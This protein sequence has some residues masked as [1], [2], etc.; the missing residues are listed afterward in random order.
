MLYK[1]S[2]KF[3]FSVMIILGLVANMQ[4]I[5]IAY[6]VQTLTNI[7][8]RK[9]WGNLFQFFLVISV[10]FILI[11]LS[12]LIFNRLKTDTVRDVNIYLRTNIFRGMLDQTKENNANGLG[13]LTND[14]KLLE[15]NRFDAQIEIIMEFFSL[16]IALGYA[17]TIN[18]QITLLFLLGSFIPM[19]ISN[20]FQNNIQNAAKKWSNSNGRYVNQTKNFLA[21]SETLCLYHGQDSATK[22]NKKYVDKLENSLKKMNLANLDTESWV[23]FLAPIVTF[24]IPFLFGIFLVVNGQTELGALFAIVQLANSFVNPILVILEDRNKLSTTK[25]IVSKID[26]FLKQSKNSS[27]KGKDIFNQLTAKNISLARKNAKLISGLNF[28]ISKN[29]KVAII[30]PSGSGKSTL[31][32]F[33]MYGKYGTAQEV[34]VNGNKLKAGS[35]SDLFA[36]ASQTPVIFADSLWYNLTLGANIPRE[37]VKGVC[38]NLELDNII[39]EKGFGYQLGNNADQLSGGQLARIELARAILSKRSILLLD[40]INASLDKKTAKKIHNYLLESNLTFLEVIHH[41][42]KNELKLYDQVINLRKY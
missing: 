19:M 6:M 40:E 13:F 9:S 4:N 14:F 33:L 25:D 15:T 26:S 27:K 2:N 41:Y 38:H 3:K 8:T 7:A 17:L 30:G 10:G 28:S 12:S 5:L 32:Q 16:I 34:L 42:E 24:L 29:Q 23:N 20:L 11:L 1:Y 37:I 36:Y 21:G 22:K 31:L 35:F 39:Q 18:Y